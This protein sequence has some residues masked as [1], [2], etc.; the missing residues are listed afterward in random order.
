MQPLQLKAFLKP[1][2]KIINIPGYE[3]VSDGIRIFDGHYF[4]TI[5]N[6]DIKVLRCV[7]VPDVMGR[8]IFEDDL[9]DVR[10][11]FPKANF[12]ARV[13]FTN[14][15]FV[16]EGEKHVYDEWKSQEI[17]VTG[18]FNLEPLAFEKQNS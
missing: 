4:R 13:K 14:G 5:L 3:V 8:D 2:N 6:N 17:Y 15:K 1:E 11:P 16:A 7:G 10:M 18:N 12:I 9:I